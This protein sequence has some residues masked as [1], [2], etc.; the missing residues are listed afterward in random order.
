MVRE[1]T[2][3][4]DEKRKKKEKEKLGDDDDEDDTEKD[5]KP[6]SLYRRDVLNMKGDCFLY[7]FYSFFLLILYI[8]TNFTS[9]IYQHLMAECHTGPRNLLRI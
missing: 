2:L 1:N 3:N 6:G 5:K 8:F 7:L 4:E 9:V